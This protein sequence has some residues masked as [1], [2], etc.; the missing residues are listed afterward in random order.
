MGFEEMES[1][2]WKERPWLRFRA[3]E[4]ERGGKCVCEKIIERCY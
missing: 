4:R 3:G 1:E 2:N